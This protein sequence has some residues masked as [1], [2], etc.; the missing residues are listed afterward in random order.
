[1]NR[2]ANCHNKNQGPA[3]RVL[4][5]CSAGLLRSPTAAVVL[6]REFGYNTRSCGSVPDFALV[7]VDS[8]LIE[9]ADKIVCMEESHKKALMDAD[10]LRYYKGPVIVLGVPDDYEYMDPDL[11]GLILESYKRTRMMESFE[12]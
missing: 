2:R 6:Q 11:Q 3:E 5:V 8:V 7:P 10:L 4:C 1:M 12:H 9:W